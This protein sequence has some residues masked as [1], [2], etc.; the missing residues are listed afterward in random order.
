MDR[1]TKHGKVVGTAGIEAVGHKHKVKH[2]AVFGISVEKT[3]CGYRVYNRYNNRGHAYDY[4]TT[5]EVVDRCRYMT[6]VIIPPKN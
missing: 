1:G 4:K 5:D 3:Y 6:G 2:R